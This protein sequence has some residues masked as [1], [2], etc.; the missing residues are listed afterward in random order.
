MAKE[1]H[2]KTFLGD[3]WKISKRAMTIAQDKNNVCSVQLVEGTGG[4]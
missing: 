2:V 4:E 1:D 3:M